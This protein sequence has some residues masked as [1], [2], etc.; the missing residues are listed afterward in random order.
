M[1]STGLECRGAGR[2]LTLRIFSQ[3]T[4]RGE[5]GT[6]RRLPALNRAYDY[7]CLAYIGAVLVIA[8]IAQIGRLK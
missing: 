8:V 6:S 5:N 4:E 2:R 1:S 3:P 7:T